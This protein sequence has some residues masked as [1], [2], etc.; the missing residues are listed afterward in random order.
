MDTMYGAFIVLL[1]ISLNSEWISAVALHQPQSKEW[2]RN[3]TQ[4]GKCCQAK[5]LLKNYECFFRVG[6]ESCLPD[7]EYEI[8]KCW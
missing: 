2:L 3:A 7:S 4:R 5:K 8:P 1:G 6:R